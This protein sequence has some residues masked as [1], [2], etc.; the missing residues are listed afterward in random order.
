MQPS[1]FIEPT[2]AQREAQTPGGAADSL[3]DPI[4]IPV[5]GGPPREEALCSGGGAAGLFSPV[6]PPVP[7]RPTAPETRLICLT[8]VYGDT[9]WGIGRLFGM[10]AEDIA[11]MNGIPDP[12]RIFPGQR[13]FLR[14][15]AS[16]PIAACDE[17]VVRRG[18]TL[19]GI[20]ERLGLDAHA[21]A[22]LNGL[23]DPDL[24]LEGQVLRLA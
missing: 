8:T 3:F 14:V 6:D 4:D 22:R 9:L 13:L 11:R 24:I 19:T 18:D 21:L 1:F 15:P 2:G 17:Y 12:N 16:T 20:A 7:A 23:S 5:P 10:S